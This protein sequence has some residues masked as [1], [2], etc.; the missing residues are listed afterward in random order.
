LN[1]KYCDHF[2]PLARKEF[3]DI[4]SFTHDMSRLSNLSNGL[5]GRIGLMGGEPLLHPELLRFL[6]VVREYFPQT[7]IQIVTNGI[8]LLKQSDIFWRT[9]ARYKIEIVLTKYPLALDFDKIEQ[10][11]EQYNVSFKY[12]EDNKNIQKKSYFIPLNLR[13]NSNPR[14]N[15]LKCFHANNCIFLK[16]GKLFPCPIAPNINHFKGYFKDVLLTPPRNCLRRTE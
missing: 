5:V 13:G 9:C 1:C 15:F 2:S 12:F 7:I 11:A 14:I 10:Y 8:L 3:L 16:N 4:Q 6:P